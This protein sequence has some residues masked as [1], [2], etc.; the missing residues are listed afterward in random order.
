MH[1]IH[2]HVVYWSVLSQF[3]ARAA[4]GKTL[5]PRVAVTSPVVGLSVSL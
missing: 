4:H 3:V 1:I 2:V 5:H